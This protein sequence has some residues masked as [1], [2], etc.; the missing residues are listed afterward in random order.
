MWIRPL[1]VIAIETIA[2]VRA[3]GLARMLAQSRCYCNAQEI[4]QH[5]PGIPGLFNTI[6]NHPP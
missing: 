2:T 3:A 4:V 1:P 5:S 6:P